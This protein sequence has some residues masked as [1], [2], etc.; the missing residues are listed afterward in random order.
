MLNIAFGFCAVNPAALLSSPFG[1]PV[2]QVIFNAA[3]RKGGVSLW[4]WVT[5]V[6]VF[7]GATAML[8]VTRTVFALSRDEMFPGSRLLRKMNP[9]THIP[10]YSVWSVVIFCC[11]LNLIALGS[12][13][14]INGIFGITAPACDLSY[15]AV[16]LGK[17]YYGRTMPI[18]KGPFN[19]GPFSKPINIIACVWTFFISVILFF[20]PT[21]PVTA[22]NMNY[23]VAIGGFIALFATAW[24]YLGANK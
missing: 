15:A 5:L 17:L 21:Y 11:L 12:T 20:P 18:E 9:K 6:Q 19:L 7:T 1:N 4:F 14:T 8:S 3:G 16:I 10:L 13:Q 23:A 24:W 2:T 22:S